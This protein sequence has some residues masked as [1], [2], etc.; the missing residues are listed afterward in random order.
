[1]IAPGSVKICS[2]RRP[3]HARLVVEAGADAFGLIFAPARRRVSVGTATEIVREVRRLSNGRHI[4]AI[5]VFVGASADEINRTAETVGLDAAQLHGTEPVE[6][7]RAV[8]VPVLKAVRP[9]PG[10]PASDV[11]ALI[12]Q[13]VESPRPPVAFLIDGYHVSAAGG[14]GVRTDWSLAGELAASVPLVL[15]GGLNPANV[16]EAI[17][18]VRPIGVDVSS[19]V[20]TAGEKDGEAIRRFVAEARQAFARL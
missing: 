3:E 2:L 1:M 13:H 5:G 4:Q 12:E 19:G 20:E 6:T 18:A 7:V 9:A 11:R 8:I 17:A 15:S 10:T 16:G 14:T